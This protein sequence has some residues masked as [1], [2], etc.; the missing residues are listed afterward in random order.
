MTVLSPN[1]AYVA[2]EHYENASD[3]QEDI[4]GR[5]LDISD[6]GLITFPSV[7]PHLI[8]IVTTRAGN[9]TTVPVHSV[10]VAAVGSS[11]VVATWDSL[12]GN[13]TLNAT[14]VAARVVL[15]GT[16]GIISTPRD[17]FLVNSAAL[18]Q[19]WP[20]V[21]ALDSSSVLIVWNREELVGGSITY[22]VYGQRIAVNSNNGVISRSGTEVKLN[23][24]DAN[25]EFLFQSK[26]ITVLIKL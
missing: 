10:S 22:N 7:G 14:V 21:I 24:N 16:T 8:S 19:D 25:S 9:K 12:I 3:F 5:V 26:I 2:W 13:T 15:V 11:A 23:T 18:Y 20:Q 1:R 17:T 6:S 4:Y